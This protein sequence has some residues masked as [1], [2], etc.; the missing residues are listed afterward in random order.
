ME[1]GLVYF[2]I[3]YHHHIFNIYNTI[4]LIPS[5]Y[6]YVHIYIAA[7]LCNLYLKKINKY[8]I[9]L[10]KNEKKKKNI[11][12]SIYFDC[13][14]IRITSILLYKENDDKFRPPRRLFI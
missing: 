3:T 14:V 9:V 7:Y 1:E 13:A 2:L 5:V 12:P 4:L 6:F 8:S 11:T 10:I